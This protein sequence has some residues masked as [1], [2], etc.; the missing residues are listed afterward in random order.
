MMGGG[1]VSNNNL[2]MENGGDK[3]WWD[4]CEYWWSQITTMYSQNVCV[5][6]LDKSADK[7]C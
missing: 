4:I 2:V 1:W 7:C 3:I 6:N 5:L